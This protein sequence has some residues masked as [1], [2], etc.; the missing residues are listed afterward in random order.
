MDGYQ[1]GGLICTCDTNNKSNF[2]NVIGIQGPDKCLIPLVSE[3]GDNH[4]R[5]IGAGMIIESEEL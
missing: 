5:R 3:A 4:H 2:D 1:Y